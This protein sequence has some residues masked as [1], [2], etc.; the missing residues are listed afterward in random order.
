MREERFNAPEKSRALIMRFSAGLEI[1][2]PAKSREYP[3]CDPVLAG[4]L[5]IIPGSKI[6]LFPK[7]LERSSPA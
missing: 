7:A 5:K 4:R 6:Q 1:P 2:Q 3:I